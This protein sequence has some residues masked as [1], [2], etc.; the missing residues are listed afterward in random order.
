MFL[1]Q[2]IV[3][4]KQQKNTKKYTEKKMSAL[5]EQEAQIYDRQ[6]RLWGVKA[7]Q[8]IRNTRVLVYSMTGLA[9]EIWK[10]L[11][12]AGVG[13]M[14]IMDHEVVTPQL[15]ASNFLVNESHVGKNVCGE[16]VKF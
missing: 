10:N 13:N 8:R 16:R 14:C 3:Q 7:Q 6:I 2:K 9:T 5:S 12:L 1:S 4:Q 15:L 11:F